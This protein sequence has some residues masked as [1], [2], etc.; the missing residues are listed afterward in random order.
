M[1]LA[2]V[3]ASPATMTAP[4]FYL[5]RLS[6]HTYVRAAFA[7]CERAPGLKPRKGESARLKWI[8]HVLYETGKDSILTPL[9]CYRRMGSV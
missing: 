1:S 2:A 9:T 7:S 3:A 6:V 4:A 5:A 8:S